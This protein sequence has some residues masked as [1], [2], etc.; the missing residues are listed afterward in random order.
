MM[1]KGFIYH[2][3]LSLK[4]NFKSKQPL[5]YG[6]LVPIFFLVAFGAVFRNGNP[7]L[8][9]QMSQLITIS[10]LGGAC[11]GMPTAL[12]SERERGWWRRYKLFPNGLSALVLSTV[13]ARFFL[14]ASAALLQLALAHYFYGTPYPE[15]PLYFISAYLAVAFAFLG[16]GLVIAA[17][18]KDVPSVQALGQC[19]FMPLIMIGG[20]GV[21]LIVLPAWAQKVATFLPGKYACEALQSGFTSEGQGS[22]FEFN[23]LVLV[24]M[25]LCSL[26]VG[27][28]L[29]RW[30]QND[31][32]TYGARLAVIIALLPWIIVGCFA[33][34]TDAW[35]PLQ[36]APVDE[37]KSITESQMELITYDNLPPD[38][39]TVTPIAAADAELPIESSARLDLLKA[40][41]DKWAPGH[42]S[43]SAQAIRYLLCVAAVADV[44]ED[45]LEGNIA[46]LIY[47]RIQETY[48]PD[49]V[50]HGLAW[51]AL[52]PT[53]GQ[54][55]TSV[56]ELKIQGEFYEQTI[57]VRTQIYAIKFFGRIRHKLAN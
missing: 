44:N 40:N 34:K 17:F 45:Q 23:L 39:G 3:Q 5:I 4:L 42:V 54:V 8:I 29:F 35:H 25:G 49:E 27:A 1:I 31:K 36:P 37:A 20:V 41:L 16:M 56:P 12:V 21:P 57:R 50:T 18:A 10:A 32:P 9:H 15:F 33:L 11:F 24:V 7:P 30:G 48:T 46:R 22:H 51:V 43:N 53:S 55:V 52:Y 47:E 19:I 28:K 6:Y 2:F 38:D 26:I 14:I 13:L